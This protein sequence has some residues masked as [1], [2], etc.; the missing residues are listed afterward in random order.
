VYSYLTGLR[1]KFYDKTP[2]GTLVTRTISDIET[3]ADVFSEGLDQY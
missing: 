2:V 1:L 3:I